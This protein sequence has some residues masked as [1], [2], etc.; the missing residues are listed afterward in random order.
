MAV[1]KA[2]KGI[3]PTREKAKFIAARP[4][5]VLNKEE[6]RLDAKGNPFSFLHVTKPEIDLPDTLDEHDASVYDS[7]KKYYESLMENGSLVQDEKS[8]YTFMPR[9]WGVAPNTASWAA[10]RLKIT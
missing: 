3:R 10:P 4:Y 7:G 9:P 6:A 2:F 5:D 8:I 1:L